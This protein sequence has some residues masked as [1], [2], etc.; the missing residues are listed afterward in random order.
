MV[1][2]TMKEQIRETPESIPPGMDISTMTFKPWPGRFLVERED[3]DSVTRGGIHLPETS[4]E[5]KAYGK[6]ISVG[7]GCHG[8]EVGSTVLFIDNA[9]FPMPMLGEG[10][11]LLESGEGADCDVLGTFSKKT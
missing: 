7:D 10:F 9:G 6:V 11:T 5:K 3:P 1:S 8:V 4:V 2:A